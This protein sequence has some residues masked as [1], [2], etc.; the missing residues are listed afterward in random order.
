ME[1]TLDRREERSRRVSMRVAVELGLDDYEERFEADAVNLGAGGLSIRSSCLPDVGTR[2]RCRFDSSPGGTPIATDAEVVWARLDA[3]SG[4]E[5][6]LRFVDMED[7]HR[8]LIEEMLA[9]CAA[10]SVAGAN[11]PIDD[12][13][14]LELGAAGT[15][16]QARVARRGRR[17][18]RFEQRLDLLS[19]GRSLLARE[20]GHRGRQG[21]ISG[22]SLRLEEGTPVLSV[23]VDFEGELSFG[24]FQWSTADLDAILDGSAAGMDGMDGMDAATGNASHDTIP[25]LETPGA[26][27]EADVASADDHKMKRVTVTEFEAVLPR[28]VSAPASPDDVLDAPSVA[29]TLDAM[30]L[31]DRQSYPDELAAYAADDVDDGAGGPVLSITATGESSPGEHQAQSDALQ[32]PLED[33]DWDAVRDD[34]RDEVHTVATPPAVTQVQQAAVAKGPAVAVKRPG[35]AAMD[36]IWVQRALSVVAMAARGTERL[37]AVVLP[38]VM[39]WLATAASVS[40]GFAQRQLSTVGYMA[41]S[42]MHA[43]PRRR[44]TAGP[45][46]RTSAKKTS[47][48]PRTVVL[49]TMGAGVVALGVYAL[50]PTPAADVQ[51]LHR[52][53]DATAAAPELAADAPLLSAGSKASTGS[54]EVPKPASV[55]EA[56]PYAVDV[57]DPASASA[58]ASASAASVEGPMFGDAAAEGRRFALRMTAPIKN[59]RGV[60]DAGGFTV[61]VPGALSLDRAGPIAAS[62]RA[63]RSSMILNKGDHAELTIRFAP[64]ATP[65]YRVRGAGTELE[66]IIGK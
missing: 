38:V 23:N 34:A 59:L 36:S 3:G 14:T 60:P 19:L 13:A 58:S 35:A 43:K 37:R 4:G 8:G 62:H 17:S 46:P 51:P 18:A 2:L 50:A 21:S 44:T 25:D 1:T 11:A 24:E 55:P 49:A 40:T 42:R 33:Q 32:R 20:Q 41:R 47:G 30:D 63:V 29:G 45:P 65:T 57:K 56:S 5:F 9:E 10:H 53:I 39:K 31:V 6:G 16:I 26:L 12:D 15:A 22:I 28:L 27:A 7:S 61:H 66:I 54:A 64:D 52:S 48:L